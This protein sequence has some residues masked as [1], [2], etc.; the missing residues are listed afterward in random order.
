VTEKGHENPQ[1]GQ[2]ATRLRFETEPADSFYRTLAELFRYVRLIGTLTVRKIKKNPLELLTIGSVFT[3]H[4]YVNPLHTGSG[5]DESG[6]FEVCSSATLLILDYTSPCSRYC[7]CFLF[8]TSVKKVVLENAGE[9]GSI[10][11]F[12]VNITLEQ[13]TKTQKGSRGIAILFL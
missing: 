3:V 13:A 4:S 2:T 9:I 11:K 1:P 8:V 10:L 7:L 5:A 12:K 6:G